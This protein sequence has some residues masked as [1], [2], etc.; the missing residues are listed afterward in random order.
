MLSPE[1]MKKA[2]CNGANYEMLHNGAEGSMR[3]GD[4]VWQDGYWEEIA[5]DCDCS[6][7]GSYSFY[8]EGR[9]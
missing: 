1:T 7:P 8:D 2:Q 4:C 9:A 6:D 3:G 5:E